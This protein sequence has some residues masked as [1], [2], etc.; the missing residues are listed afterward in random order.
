MEEGVRGSE[1]RYGKL[2]R[3]WICCS[4]S[5]FPSKTITLCKSLHAFAWLELE[6]RSQDPRYL[7]GGA[8]RECTPISSHVKIQNL[9]I[10]LLFVFGGIDRYYS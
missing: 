6:M 2:V 7:M 9:T 5:H 3:S 4:G 10:P 8:R 1:R